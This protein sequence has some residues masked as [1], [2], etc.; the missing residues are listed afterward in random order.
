MH[1]QPTFR[2]LAAA[3]LRSRKSMLET[4]VRHLT[5]VRLTLVAALALIGMAGCSGLIDDG[6]GGLT[7]EQAAARK[8]FFTTA[9]PRFVES[10]TVCHNGSREGIGFLAG[11]SEQQIYDTIMSFDPQVVNTDAPGSSRVLTKSLHEGPELMA[12]QASDILQWI[13]L[14]KAAVPDPGSEGPLLETAQFQAQICT[15]AS[16]PGSPTCPINTVSLD[17]IGVTGAKIQFVAQ[18]FGSALYLTELK[19][20][21][22]AGG[23]YIEHPLFVSWPAD[24][25][26]P[27][28]DSLDRFFN[29]KMNLQAAAPPEEQLIAGG[30]AAFVGFV[31][32]DKITIH[33]RAAQLFKTDD[34]GG[35]GTIEAGCKR[36]DSFKANAQTSFAQPVAGAPQ[37]CISCHASGNAQSAVNM[38]GVQAADDV[39]IKAACDQIRTRVDFQNTAS[40]GIYIAP[41][42]ANANHPFKFNATQLAAFKAAVDKWIADEK[43]A[44]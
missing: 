5:M 27:V 17:S 21:P 13:N 34:G 43:V 38:V 35:G 29:V 22:G 31:A 36:L 44:P 6:S 39:A 8:A 14:E 23:A 20:V 33:F 28:P 42:P 15:D 24:G 1:S 9:L 37:S 4:L 26:D 11:G 19:V 40:S 18:A 10:C 41:D 16:T 12:E 2:V 3:G 32:T 7:P 30:L 25:S